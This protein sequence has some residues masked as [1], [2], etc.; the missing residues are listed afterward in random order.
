MA[1]SMSAKAVITD[2]ALE[3]SVSGANENRALGMA[4]GISTV[5]SGFVS[6]SGFGGRGF[7]GDHEIIEGG[8]EGTI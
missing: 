3:R 6:V 2:M 5:R 8:C 4:G 1:T 7:P